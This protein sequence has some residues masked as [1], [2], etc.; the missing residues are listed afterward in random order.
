MGT[1]PDHMKLIDVAGPSSLTF[2]CGDLPADVTVFAAGH[3][4]NGYLWGGVVEYLAGACY[5]R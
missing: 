3:K 4:P 1:V 5:R 2:A